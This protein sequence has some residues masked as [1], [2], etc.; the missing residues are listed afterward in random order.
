MPDGLVADVVVR[1]AAADDV[2]ALVACSAALFA[3]DAGT[4]DDTMDLEWPRKHAAARFRETVADP[5]RL[6][7]VAVRAARSWGSLSAA[8][9]PA[10]PMSL[11]LET[12]A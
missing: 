11:V 2:P 1:R 8:L 3:E 9:V 4:R 12:V 6:V 5:S 10:T 7:L